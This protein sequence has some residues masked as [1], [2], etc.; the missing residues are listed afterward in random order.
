M[1]AGYCLYVHIFIMKNINS[2]LNHLILKILI[3]SC[4]TFSFSKV[5]AIIKYNMHFPVLI[6]TDN[7][8]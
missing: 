1:D 2:H 5:G 4:Q 3:N 7:G 8:S 6:K